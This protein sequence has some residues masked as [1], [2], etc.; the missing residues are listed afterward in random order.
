LPRLLLKQKAREILLAKNYS[1]E[2]LHEDYEVQLD[3][4]VV[5]VD[6]VAFQGKRKIAFHTSEISV[7]KAIQLCQVFDEVWMIGPSGAF[8]LTTLK[9]A[10]RFNYDK[11]VD[12]YIGLAKELRELQQ[13]VKKQGKNKGLRKR[14]VL[15]IRCRKAVED[16]FK[17][18]CLENKL[19]YE[20][21]IEMLLM[22]A[23][24]KDMFERKLL[25]MKLARRPD[26]AVILK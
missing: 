10:I 6:V 7:E 23:G 13:I 16:E 8:C 22:I 2:V 15:Q 5:K 9:D 3:A 1:P 26:I 24:S 25:E 18:F 17:R 14:E 4:E 19:E 11:L 20:R 12:E 21:A